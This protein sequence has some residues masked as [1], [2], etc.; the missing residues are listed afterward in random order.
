MATPSSSLVPGTFQTPDDKAGISPKAYLEFL[1]SLEKSL[2]TGS[3][4]T[5]NKASSVIMI[6]GLC[7]FCG[8]FP[9]LTPASRG[10][11]NERITLTHHILD[12]LRIHS[13]E[14]ESIFSGEDELLRKL[15]VCLLGLCVAS[16]AWL[17]VGGDQVK[18]SSNPSVLY[19]KTCD[20]FVDLMKEWLEYSPQSTE[21]SAVPSVA[22]GFLMTT[23]DLVNGMRLF[24]VIGRTLTPSD[25]LNGA[26]DQG[27]PLG[28]SFSSTPRL[29]PW[30]AC[31]ENIPVRCFR[32]SHESCL[33]GNR[34]LLPIRT[35]SDCQVHH[36]IL[37]SAVSSSMCSAEL[38]HWQRVHVFSRATW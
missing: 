12:I 18:D 33:K 4:A 25:V 30:L 35:P 7:D 6:S 5:R 16:E 31:S 22:L 14:F 8:S 19:P 24:C 23:I 17:S 29:V 38:C 26:Q 27:Y 20:T 10:T 21:C 37:Y 13:R 9:F 28:L 32:F 11:S 36:I 34:Y 2:A 1:D 3:T 15:S